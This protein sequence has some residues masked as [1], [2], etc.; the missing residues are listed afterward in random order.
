MN[1]K[2]SENCWN[3]FKYIILL[4][5]TSQIPSAVDTSFALRLSLSPGQA[6]PITL[7]INVSSKSSGLLDIQDAFP[8]STRLALEPKTEQDI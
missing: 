6:L 7:E 8:S 2:F 3:F 4:L 1:N 5:I